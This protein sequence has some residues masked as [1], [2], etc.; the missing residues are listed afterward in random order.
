MEKLRSEQIFVAVIESSRTHP[1]TH[2]K[3][4]K[5]PSECIHRMLIG[6]SGTQILC[7]EKKVCKFQVVE[8]I[9]TTLSVQR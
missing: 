7:T 9:S 8:I 3:G 2:K 4:R 5:M 1:H 6:L